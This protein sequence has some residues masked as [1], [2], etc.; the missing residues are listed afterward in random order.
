MTVD[1]SSRVLWG[2]ESGSTPSPKGAAFDELVAIARRIRQRGLGDPNPLIQ[3]AHEIRGLC[4]HPLGNHRYLVFAGDKMGRWY[5][6]ELDLSMPGQV[7]ECLALPPV[8]DADD[9]SRVIDRLLTVPW[10]GGHGVVLG[11]RGAGAWIVPMESLVGEAPP[12]R[13]VMVLLPGSDGRY[14]GPWVYDPITQTLLAAAH[15]GLG[16]DLFQW[17]LAEAEPRLIDHEERF[18]YP[19]TALTIDQAVCGD[20]RDADFLFLATGRCELFRFERQ[21]RDRFHVSLK[22][23][24]ARRPVWKG[25]SAPIHHL[26]PFSD[27]GIADPDTEAWRR[28]FRQ[29]G[30][31]AATLR[32]LVV[33]SCSRVGGPEAPARSQVRMVIGHSRILTLRA[34]NARLPEGAAWHGLAVSTLNGEL[35]IYRSSEE[36]VDG[37][38]EVDGMPQDG[39]ATLLAEF[40][41]LVSKKVPAVSDRVYQLGCLPPQERLGSSGFTPLLLGLG[42]HRVTW[43]SYVPPGIL[44]ALARDQ[45]ARWL[46]GGAPFSELLDRLQPI[47]L[48]ARPTHQE[49]TAILALI[50]ELGRVAETVDDWQR[51]FLL[52]WDVLGGNTPSDVAIGMVRALREVQLNLT[53]ELGSLELRQLVAQIEDELT[54]IQK[55][56]LDDGSFSRKQGHLL[57]LADPADPGLEDERVIYRSILVSRRFDSLFDVCSDELGEVRTL[58]P[59][60]AADGGSWHESRNGSPRF[61]ISN[62][63]GELWIFDGSGKGT[64]LLEAREGWGHVRATY[65][66]GGRLIL[67]FSSG[68]VAALPSE[69]LPAVFEPPPAGLE[70]LPVDGLPEQ[71]PRATAFA[72]W[73]GA[74]D[75]FL[76]GDDRGRLHL[77]HGGEPLFDLAPIL[78]RKNHE[79]CRIACLRPEGLEEPGLCVVVGTSTGWLLLL[80]PESDS[81][82]AS[83]RLELAS[84]IAIDGEPVEA[85]LV[86]GTRESRLLAAS[87]SNLCC[88]QVLSSGGELRL[89]P[90]WAFRAGDLIRGVESFPARRREAP[91]SDPSEA[92]AISDE[93]LILVSSHDQ[94]LYSLDLEGRHLETYTLSRQTSGA[95][96]Q[97]LKAGVFKVAPPGPGEPSDVVAKVYLCAFENRFTGIR[98][99]D[100]WR[101]LDAITRDLASMDPNRRELSMARWRAYQVTE[102]HLRHRFIRQSHRYPGEN[103]EEVIAALDQV[104]DEGASSRTGEVT[105]LLRRL[106]QN[107]APGSSA[108]VSSGGLRQ[109]LQDPEL[110]GRALRQLRDFEERWDTPNSAVNRRVQRYWIRSFLRNVEDLET[111]RLWLS[112]GEALGPCDSLARPVELVL[113]F[114]DSA[115]RTVRVKTLQYLEF[116]VFGQP[117]RGRGPLLEPGHDRAEGLEWFL[118]VLLVTLERQQRKTDSTTDPV[119]LRVGRLLAL[120]ICRGHLG[121]LFL[122]YR[123]QQARVDLGFSRQIADQCE[124]IYRADPAPVLTADPSP[125]VRLALALDHKLE[126]SAPLAEIVA[127]LQALVDHIDRGGG[128]DPLYRQQARAYFGRLIPLLEAQD[129][130]DLEELRS[131]WQTP[132]RAA[133]FEYCPSYGRLAELE[134]VL[135]KAGEYYRKKYEDLWVDPVMTHLELRDFAGLR[136]AWR[137]WREAVEGDL[138]H[139]DPALVPRE[140]RLLRRL[141]ASWSEIFQ[142]EQ[143]SA[144]LE[145]FQQMVEE[146]CF[147]DIEPITHFDAENLALLDQEKQLAQTAFTNL[148][149]R[150]IL[151]AEPDHAVFLYRPSEGEIGCEWLEQDGGEIRL[152]TGSGEEVRVPWIADGWTHPDV[153]QR[154]DSEAIEKHLE[155]VDPGGCWAVESIPGAADQAGASGFYLLGWSDSEA[156]GWRKFRS[157]RLA[158]SVPLQALVYRRAAMRQEELKG[159]LF[160]II[161]HNLGTPIFHMRSDLRVLVDGFLESRPDKRQAKYRQ[162]LRQARQ[163]DSIVDGILSLSSRSVERSLTE[164]SLPRLVYEVV[165]TVRPEARVKSVRIEFPEPTP[166]Q[167]DASRV[168][169]DETKVYDILLNVLSNAVKYS[170]EDAAVDVLLSVSAKGTDIQVSDR[171]PGIPESELELIFEPFYRGRSAVVRKGSGLGLGL[172][173]ARLYTELLQGR[174]RAHNRPGGGATFSLFLPTLDPQ[175]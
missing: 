87:G 109:I 133:S 155:G 41:K 102:G 24:V 170:P 110:Y 83:P 68:R 12:G 44:E 3:G 118:E 43:V 92:A 164:V 168:S 7:G 38:T 31:V 40:D 30:V 58:T 65:W 94:H 62:Y 99:V 27:F 115:S 157:S 59:I 174:I 106:F 61:V 162:L 158:W 19:V 53:A 80:T 132:S 48:S 52:V 173:V 69:A 169:T 73:P 91:A 21:G 88:L 51:L 125:V 50:P 101:L 105:A 140:R 81:T 135:V 66:F 64:R 29:R 71:L 166:E 14:L 159:R 117:V 134:P 171:G 2:G 10:N 149:T 85:L 108:E 55:F 1:G 127:V 120:L 54:A 123:L 9:R 153:F 82:S 172:Y 4:W 136:G 154:L 6:A 98:L 151:H 113:H 130:Q 148:F 18:P 23:L 131:R 33:V 11:T 146:H 78:P 57:E 152:G 20:S 46:D 119:S 122:T 103:P 25:C 104:L 39:P 32:R 76:W 28:A 77:S 16:N 89:A 138:A 60:P 121:P 5:R 128:P 143:S 147:Q 145:D 13:D 47:A 36:S 75:R 49:R 74:P 137:H 142:R 144:L 150:L 112:V 97:K 56:V 22:R 67:S 111:M 45:A 84:K 156:E 141:L 167:A 26:V 107:R 160:S 86:A 72:A 15:D 114:L 8:P 34:I 96:R 17:S 100:R 63:Q 139:P 163:I 42:D 95:R 165:R 79:I 93:D 129:L 116:L 37:L 161:A 175:E 124:A 126:A 70:Y 90:L 35:R